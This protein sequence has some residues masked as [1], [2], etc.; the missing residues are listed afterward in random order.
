MAIPK[1]STATSAQTD[2]LMPRVVW[3]GGTPTSSVFRKTFGEPI[4]KIADLRNHPEAAALF[5]PFGMVRKIQR[6]L[7][8]LSRKRGKIVP[9]KGITASA[10]NAC[11]ETDNENLV[12]VGMEF[13][14]RY[15]GEEETVAGV[16]SHEWGHL[17]SEFPVGMNPDD[18]TWD[19]IFEIRKEEEAA[20]DS[21]A[22]RML[23][24]MGYTPEGLC[25]FLGKTPSAKES[26]KYH[27]VPTRL[28]IVRQAFA[29][30]RRQ[31]EQVRKMCLFDQP[32]YGNPFAATLIAVV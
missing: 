24:L 14:G 12:F 10:L 21:Y 27:S 18:L 19:E 32:A 5:G 1:L 15:Q 7:T 29:E 30:A 31:Q 23:L 22:G 13:L 8:T 28:A 2:L 3:G 6:K 20:A 9:A 17:I 25:R 26:L 11:E 16:L 4:P